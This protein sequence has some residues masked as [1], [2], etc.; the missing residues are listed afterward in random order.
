MLLLCCWRVVALLSS[1]PD[2]HFPSTLAWLWPAMWRLCPAATATAVVLLPTGHPVFGILAAARCSCA[3]HHCVRPLRVQRLAC[4]HA[5]LQTTDVL[6]AARQHL[7]FI[8]VGNK[9]AGQRDYA[10]AVCLHQFRSHIQLALI[11]HHRVTHCS[12]NT[13]HTCYLSVASILR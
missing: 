1:V 7:S 4:C 6:L 8:L 13:A 5:S 2:S 12:H 3:A 10:G 11:T 9:H